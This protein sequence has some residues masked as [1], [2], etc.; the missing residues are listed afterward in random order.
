MRKGII[1]KYTIPSGNRPIDNSEIVKVCR[2]YVS[3]SG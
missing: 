2:H 1:Y 3:P